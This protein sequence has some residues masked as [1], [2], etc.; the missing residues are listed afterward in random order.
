MKS[1]LLLFIIIYTML[2]TIMLV[3]ATEN[4]FISSLIPGW[5]TVMINSNNLWMVLMFCLALTF[6]ACYIM[7]KQGITKFVIPYLFLSLSLTVTAA[8]SL[9]FYTPLALLLIAAFTFVL[10]QLFFLML[11]LFQTIRTKRLKA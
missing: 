4:D 7:I 6:C 9:A 10:G 8:V 11:L 2:L 5:N 1:K 3:L